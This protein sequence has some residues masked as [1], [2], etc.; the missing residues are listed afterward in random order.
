M[1][2]AFNQTAPQSYMATCPKGVEHGLAIELER[3]GAE[4]VVESV[5]AVYF[6][7]GTRIAY[8]I[9]LWSRLANRIVAL[10]L[11]SRVATA[12]SLYE[13]VLALDWS[14]WFDSDQT[15]SIDFSGTSTCVRNERY[16]QQRVKDAISDHFV[17]RGR[18]RVSVDPIHSDVTI[19]A[20]LFKDKFSIGIDMVGDSLH[21]RGYRQSTGEAP[22]KE[23]LAATLLQQAGWLDIAKNGGGFV[24]LMCGSGTLVIEAAMMALDIAPGYDRLRWALQALQNYDPAV[25]REAHDSA[26][27]RRDIALGASGGKST[28]AF[29]A[30]D[31][32]E[33]A[34]ALAARHIERAGLSQKI[35]LQRC[36][37][38]DFH[39][40]ETMANGLVMV[41]PPYGE[42][43]G[44][45]EDLPATYRQLG[46]TLL[47]EFDGWQAAIFTGD[48][49]LGWSTGLRSWR[50][51]RFYNGSIDCQLQRYRIGRDAVLTQKKQ[52]P[53]RVVDAGSLS[54]SATMLANRLRK[55]LRRLKSWCG[56]QSNPT[57]RVYDRDLPEYAVVIDCYCA[58]AVAGDPGDSASS[59]PWQR[60][61]PAKTL[62]AALHSP[63]EP[64][65]YLH[66]QEYAAPDS[67]DARQA[68]RRLDEALQAVS[69]VFNCPPQRIVLKTRQ[70]QSGSEQYRKREDET[71]DMVIREDGRALLV[72]L[73]RYLDTG[74]F[75]D[76][77]ALRR[78]LAQRT[79][80]K[81]FLN[82]FAY[83]GTA[84]VASAC[85]GASATLSVD[86]S[87]T[88]LDW[89]R[90]NFILNDIE[91]GTDS[92]QLVRADALVWLAN[93]DACFD[94]I[95]LDPP[96][97]SNS[98]KMATTLDIQRDHT[99]LVMRCMARFQKPSRRRLWQRNQHQQG[100]G[101]P[102]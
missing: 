92:H 89:A 33:S 32:S 73:S 39:L 13:Q 38:A 55:N 31:V 25:W 64:V 95:L 62:R 27:E 26:C 23:N 75:L 15:L 37:V 88:Y 99:A 82:L 9:C 41:N 60:H 44:S 10:M 6:S 85:A 28:I 14:V 40:R 34:V 68:R 11:R 17:A 8:D 54:D 70:R 2:T 18:P 12:D 65:L 56:K 49:E 86:M 94:V 58:I 102:C 69:V 45:R 79:R 72:N 3:L 22:L 1:T 5:A 50:Q 57:F 76:T 19:Y 46:D 21:R 53:E 30:S 91:P 98:K 63:H 90:D 61:S 51:H 93:T 97:F 87:N 80:G 81:R 78:L 29:L 83:T 48:R 84:T 47:R 20:R 96:S 74:V 59:N 77:R 67:I 66:V 7:A 52:D 4:S 35:T 42:R 36:A 24:D 71:P 43:L 100:M 101:A 16:G